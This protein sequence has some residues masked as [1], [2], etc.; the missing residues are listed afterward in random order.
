MQLV[1]AAEDFVNVVSV[2]YHDGSRY[3]H[4]ERVASSPDWLAEL[5][6]PK[7]AK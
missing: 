3:P 7:A 2:D 1:F 6:K 5:G 4:L